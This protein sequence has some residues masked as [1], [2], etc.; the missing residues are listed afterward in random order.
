MYEIVR[1]RWM[2]L[3][4]VLLVFAF[5]CQGVTPADQPPEKVDT[6]TQ[7]PAIIE[8]TQP[9]NTVTPTPLPITIR[10][11]MDDN[12]KNG[13]INIEVLEGDYQ[14][15]NG[16]T[17]WTGSSIWAEE[18][19]LTF[20]VGLAI[21]VGPAGLTL[22][23]VK[24]SGDTTLFV[25]RENHLMIVGETA[26]ASSDQS[27]NPAFRDD[28]DGSLDEG[29]Q[30][31]GEDPSHWNLTNVP[32]FLRITLQPSNIAPDGR[33]RNFLVRAFPGGD[34]QIETFVIF[35]PS[36]NFQFAGLLIYETQGKAMQFGRAFA[37]CGFEACKGNA[38]Y[39]DLAD[40]GV[41]SPPNFVTTVGETSQAWLRLVRTGNRYEGY[42]SAD[43]TAWKSIGVHTT[44][45]AP[46]YIGLIGSQALE[47][48]T[49][50]DFDYFLMEPIP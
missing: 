32:G 38:I 40:P 17:L 4:S 26:T 45:I 35:E 29:W 1:A 15:A 48:E 13:E 9:A 10:V 24:Y 12:P 20:P 14:L 22:K 5:A 2:L 6:P 27:V 23:G 37:N 34:F 30:W 49:T 8:A 16:T 44:N 42:Y 7:T 18:Q 41:V 25:D 36:S 21:E 33:A 19:Y 31:L 50:A 46:V 43:G 39:F 28:F 47:A 11:L 3:I